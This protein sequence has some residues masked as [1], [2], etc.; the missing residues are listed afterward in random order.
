MAC[1]FAVLITGAD[2]TWL[3]HDVIANGISITY[4]IIGGLLVI[5]LIGTM[6]VLYKHH[7]HYTHRLVHRY[8][9]K[10]AKHKGVI[11]VIK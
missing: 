6:Y 4:G 9:N 8:I 2:L 1:E 3:L 11:C 10:R 7:T 5:G